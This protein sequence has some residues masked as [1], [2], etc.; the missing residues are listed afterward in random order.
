MVIHR[1]RCR[2]QYTSLGR[3]SRREGIGDLDS[4]LVNGWNINSVA[5]RGGKDNS[6]TVE[7]DRSSII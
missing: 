5:A 6:S 7:D 4:G 1:L 2:Q 3:A